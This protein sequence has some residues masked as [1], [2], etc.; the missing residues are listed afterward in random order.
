MPSRL[1]NLLMICI[2]ISKHMQ[3]TTPRNSFYIDKEIYWIFNTCLAISASFSTKCPL[4]HHNCIIFCSNNTH[5]FHESCI[6]LSIPT[7]VGWST[8]SVLSVRSSAYTY[9]RKLQVVQSKCLCIV[10]RALGSSVRN[11]QIRIWRF[12]CLLTTS[13]HY[14]TYCHLY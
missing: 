8:L 2:C 9:I 4:F 10:T 6:K 13:E 12:Q 1:L 14:M 3:E 7:L 11:K 5:V